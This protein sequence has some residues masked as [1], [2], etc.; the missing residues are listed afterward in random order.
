MKVRI[1]LASI[2]L[3]ILSG[4]VLWPRPGRS[5]A[6]DV[7]LQ[8]ARSAKREV[9]G[10]AVVDAG[11]GRDAGRRIIQS[12]GVGEEELVVTASS[13][14]QYGSLLKEA[15]KLGLDV[16]SIP[17]L[18]TVLLRGDGNRLSD[19][20]G[21]FAYSDV[22]QSVNTRIYMIPD[23]EEDKVLTAN[24]GRPF[25]GKALEWLGVDKGVEN[26]GQGVKVAILDTAVNRETPSLKDSSISTVDLFGLGTGG[27]ESAHGTM[28][29]S[30]LAGGSEEI[31]GVAPKVEVIS[32]PVL[33]GDGYGTEFNL[34]K[35]IVEAVDRGVN[36][37][38]MSLGYK[39]GS[40]YLSAA[41][42]YAESCGVVVVASAGNEGASG[43]GDSTVCY[44]AAY[45]S[46]IAVGAV[47]ADG[48][49][50]SFSSTGSQVSLTAPGVGLYAEDDLGEPRVFSGTSASAPCVAGVIA[51]V[52]SQ[53]EGMTATEAAALVLE[54]AND[55]G[56]PGKD[57]E[58]GMGYPDAERVLYADEAGIFDPAAA[59]VAC[60]SNGDGTY[61]I[62]VSAQNQG[63]VVA[64]SI[65]LTCN[66]EEAG[67]TRTYE[68]TFTDVAAGQVV[69]G[70]ISMKAAPEGSLCY[71]NT[72]VTSV[73]DDDT[74]NNTSSKTIFLE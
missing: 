22:I 52:M 32:F 74:K 27:S 36:I 59:G 40:S 19:L 69:S 66:I 28:V 50:A 48:S 65:T 29:A 38:T 53:K 30:V 31:T 14:E 54:N 73:I 16:R 44:P 5:D 26:R 21:R 49:L 25:R 56:M 63:T 46:V 41:V 23:L 13:V 58:Y 43:S 2:V 42:E 71:V 15:K 17:V 64:D 45:K 35:A 20:L 72:E 11:A 33:D 68:H 24:S 60:M 51:Y 37:I 55:A 10:K 9:L 61:T 4:V 57:S 6:A 39:N 12:S 18:R 67:I 8:K 70:S 1:A 62:W 7:P 34:A 47:D 3:L